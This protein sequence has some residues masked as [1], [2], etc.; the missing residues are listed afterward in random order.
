M[1]EEAVVFFEFDMKSDDEKE[2]PKRRGG[3]R[4][5]NGQIENGDT[6]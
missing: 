5:K 1:V 6:M 4:R 2:V 3:R